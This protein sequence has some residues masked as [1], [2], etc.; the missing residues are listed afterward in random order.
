[1]G[2]SV[3]FAFPG[4]GCVKKKESPWQ[5]RLE[6]MEYWVEGKGEGRGRKSKEKA[7]IKNKHFFFKSPCSGRGDFLFLIIF[8]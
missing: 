1:M 8:P 2:R 3:G 4:N 6:I 7:S 5:Q